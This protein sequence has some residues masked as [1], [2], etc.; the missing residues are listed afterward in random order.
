MTSAAH[1]CLAASALFLLTGLLTGVW[2][3]ACM[4]S[5]PDATA[6]VYVDIAHRTALMYSFACLVMQQLVPH[7]PVSAELTRWV[8]AIPIGFFALAVGSYVLHGILRDTD[9]QLR[10]PH[11]LGS[12]TLPGIAMKALMVS[13]IIGE[14]GGVGILVYGVLTSASP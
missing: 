4:A 9:N 6:P 11:R 1:F 14:V 8:V 12:T 7:S 3:Y 5:S 10:S 2:K 13:L